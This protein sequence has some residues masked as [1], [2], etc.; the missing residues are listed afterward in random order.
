MDNS[1]EFEPGEARSLYAALETA[2]GVDAAEWPRLATVGEL[3]AFLTRRQERAGDPDGP[4][5]TTLTFLRLRSALDGRLKPSTPLASLAGR[6]PNDFRRD[7]AAATGLE[8]PHLEM[9][10]KGLTAA[11]LLFL[12]L[13]VGLLVNHLSPS[14]PVLIAALL[15]WPLIAVVAFTDG[16]RI[17]ADCA[18]LGALARQAAPLN[19]KRLGAGREAPAGVREILLALLDDESAGRL[20]RDQVTPETRLFATVH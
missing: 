20:P 4:Y 17:P 10:R 11:I 7:L 16:G 5:M 2:F 15:A 8:L 9:S 18:T 19:Y 14:T 1:F 12:A 3:E 13:P 6:R